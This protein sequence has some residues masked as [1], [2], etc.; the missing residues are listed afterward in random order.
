MSSCRRSTP[1]ASRCSTPSPTALVDEKLVDR[2]LQPRPARRSASSACSTRTGRPPSR[3]RSTSTTPESRALA[4]ELARRSVVL[5]AN[6]GTLPLPAAR[7]VAV[8]GPRAD[9]P[10]AMLGCY[11]FPMHVLVHYPTARDGP[12]HPHRA[13]GAGRHL[14]RH[15]RP[16]LPGPRW[17]AT[18]TSPRPS[19]PPPR[20]TSVWP[21]WAT[22]PGLFG[23]GTSGEGCDVADLRL[24]GRQE[25]LLE[26][27]LATGTPVVAVL[28]VGRPYDLSRQAD[29]LGRPGLRVL[30]GRGGRPRRS[31]TC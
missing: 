6:D 21:C 14:R 16:G 22:R 12:G 10:E 13:G 15:L 24:P 30:P 18:R 4:L 27:L 8:V 7:R 20:Q 5:L 25:E 31:P 17:A 2:A 29:R 28:L 11:S 3:R 9:T 23:N 1:T 26:A 19:R